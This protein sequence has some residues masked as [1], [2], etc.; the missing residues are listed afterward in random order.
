MKDICNRVEDLVK[1]ILTKDEKAREC[2]NLLFLKVCQQLDSEVLTVPF[3]AVLTGFN[4]YDVP[5]FSTVSRARRKVQAQNPELKAKGKV[6]QYRLEREIMFE[7][8][9]KERR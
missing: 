8:Y 5:R 2:D 9:A 1:D 4:H 3:G 7:E 6:A